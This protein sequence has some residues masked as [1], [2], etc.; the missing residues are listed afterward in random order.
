[1][2]LSAE[3]ARRARHDRRRGRDERRCSV[4]C[5]F[6]ALTGTGTV[7]SAALMMLDSASSLGFYG[8]E[9]INAIDTKTSM[10]G[11]FPAEL[12]VQSTPIEGTFT[13]R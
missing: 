5:R 12:D 9:I 2:V 6:D 8:Q 3:A 7:P 10:V 13:T 4:S 11:T 1:M